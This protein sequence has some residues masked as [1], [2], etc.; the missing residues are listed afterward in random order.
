MKIIHLSDLHFGTERPE[1]IPL[2][3]DE[4]NKID[5]DIVIIS[6]DITQRAKISQFQAAKK[7]LDSLKKPILNV[8]GNHDISLYNLFSRFF[9]TFIKYQ[10]YIQSELCNQYVDD[11]VAILGINSVTPFKPMGGYI[12][13]QQLKSVDNFFEK[14]PKNKIKIIV[15]HHNLIQSQR[16]KIIND[17]EKIIKIF[18]RN[19]VNLILSGHIHSAQIEK[20]PTNSPMYVITAGTAIST[21]TMEANSFNIIELNMR[22]FKIQVKMFENN[23]FILKKEKILQ[24]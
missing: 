6:G 8:P 18:A 19:N 4:V 3:I 23:G 20:L 2:V 21:R 9:L 7:F 16:H 14:Q 15:M 5:P 10:H 12:T 24:L 1:L 13:N 22:E 11:K 17:S